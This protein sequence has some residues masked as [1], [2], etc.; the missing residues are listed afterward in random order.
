MA[1]VID[2]SDLD[3]PVQKAIELFKSSPVGEQLRHLDMRGGRCGRAS[4]RFLSALIA[5]GGSGRLLEWG[6]EGSWHH[7]V[8]I[9]G[10]TVVV[11]WTAAQFEDDP[12]VAA[13]VGFPR[14]EP[15]H[16]ALARW[17]EPTVIDVDDRG[18]RYFHNIPELLPWSEAQKGTI[19]ARGS[20]Q[21]ATF[22][23]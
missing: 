3:P 12:A 18:A 15:L 23:H 11:D 19:P 6:W 14:I 8:L 2:P 7:A 5:C 4:C 9:D 17:G 20:P 16:D 21:E 22:R 13:S 10:T 1:H